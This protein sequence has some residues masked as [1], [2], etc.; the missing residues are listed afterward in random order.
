M[1][2]NNTDR[3]LDARE[4]SRLPASAERQSTATPDAASSNEDG[5]QWDPRWRIAYRLSQFLGAGEDL[6]WYRKVAFSYPSD[7][8][9]LAA[10]ETWSRL[11]ETT[12]NNKG[13][14]FTGILKNYHEKTK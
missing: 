2:T 7:V 1:N 12:L 13:A 6:A 4:R 3:S 9:L 5:E 11:Q 8:V 14:Y 10:L